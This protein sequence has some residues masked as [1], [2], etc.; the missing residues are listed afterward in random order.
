MPTIRQAMPDDI[1][2]LVDLR[3]QFLAE[4]G[5]A[6]PDVP[7]AVRRYMVQA[8]PAGDYVAWL[9]EQASQ[10][11]ATGGF[12]L[13]QKVPHARNLSGREAFVLNIYTLP[14]HRRQGIATALMHT[15]LEDVRRRGITT[16]RLHA[17]S[18]GAAIYTRLGFHPENTEM[19]WEGCR[20]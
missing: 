1:D 11:V 6:G 8:V 7:D 5:Y 13:T 4:I 2:T 3:L 12:V 16:V 18:D 17:T 15:L 10:P 14:R 19:V 20:L 9:A